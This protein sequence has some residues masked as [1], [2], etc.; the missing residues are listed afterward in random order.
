MSRL[1]EIKERH[2]A[3]DRWIAGKPSTPWPEPTILCLHNDRTYLLR[4]VDELEEE[5]FR[6][7]MSRADDTGVLSETWARETARDGIAAARKRA[8]PEHSEAE[9]TQ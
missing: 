2:V 1:D 8:E 4:L 3:H 7:V 5:V 9:E 6:A